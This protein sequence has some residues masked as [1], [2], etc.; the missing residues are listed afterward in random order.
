MRKTLRLC[1]VAGS[2]PAHSAAAW[3]SDKRL[4][5]PSPSVPPVREGVSFHAS[6]AMS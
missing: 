4:R 3:C 5:G 2:T 6:K 1:A